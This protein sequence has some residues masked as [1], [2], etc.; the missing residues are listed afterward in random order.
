MR[1]LLMKISFAALG[2][3]VLYGCQPSTEAISEPEIP[4][5]LTA[6]IEVSSGARWSLTGTLRARHEIP[7]AFRIGG[8]IAQRAVDAG[9]RVAQGR[10]LFRLDPSDVEQEQI[11]ARATLASARAEHENAER[12]RVRLDG[13]LSRKLTSQQ[14]YD[15]AATAARAAHEQIKAAEARLRQASNAI[16]Y[17]ALSAPTAGVI[18]DVVGQVGQVV[19]AG[20]TLAT[21]AGDGPLEAEVDVP[22]DRLARLPEVAMVHPVGG[23]QPIRARLREI[24]GAA[25]PITRTWRARYRLEDPLPG[26]ALG[27][28]LSLRFVTDEADLAQPLLRV[29]LGAVLERGDSPSLW[30]VVDGRAE[31]EPVELVRMVGEYAEIRTRLAPGTAVIALGVNR[32]YQGQAVRTHQQ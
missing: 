21:L 13:L 19:S 25:D 15:R 1:S 23:G 8:E 16:D 12:E 5:V 26:L 2:L 20:Q 27:T 11:A 10:V 31:P 3:C 17:A 28:T 18:L 29:P 32:L 7:L 6:P 24:A 9:E 30:R 14:E 4:W 22:E